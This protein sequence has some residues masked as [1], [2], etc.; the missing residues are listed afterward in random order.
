MATKVKF[1]LALLVLSGFC[2]DTTFAEV[3][4]EQARTIAREAYLYGFPIVD[5]YRIMYSYTQDRG[6]KEYKGPVNEVHGEARVFTPEDKALQTPNS[7][8]PYS[9]LVA[10]LRE[11]PLV[12]TVPEVEK[13]RYV[14]VQLIDLY[15]FNFEY[16]GTRTTGNGGGRYLLVGPSE[17]IDETP[18]GIQKILRAET[19]LVLAIYRTQLFGPDDLVNV[20]KIQEGYQAE[21]LWKYLKQPPK[22]QTPVLPLIKPLAA[23]DER[24]SVEFFDILRFALGLCPVHPEEKELRERF[25]KINLDM[26]GPAPSALPAD[27]K[28]AMKEG[29]EDGQREI[30]AK[31]GETHSASEI[32]GSRAFLQGNFLNRA[33]G[34]QM[35]IYGNSKEEAFY[36]GWSTESDQVTPLDTAKNRYVVRF[37]P[38][39]LPPVQAFWSVTMYDLP[40]Q[41]LVPNKLKRYL[42][43]SPMLPDLKK[44]AD[45]GLTIYIQKNSPGKDKESN[46]LPAPNGNAFIILRAYLPGPEILHGTWKVPPIERVK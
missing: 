24:T 16:L 37:G 41:L 39:Q 38:G 4:P 28:A 43:N 9:M 40:A 5:N 10:D 20:K 1:S 23:P 31:R 17:R 14:S 36:G 8:T 35:G 29:M 6:D 27:V 21:P 13:G 2:A 3:N 32:M 45:G 22:P 34:T 42:I 25:R 33:V 12:L 15:T 19:N 7:D 46:W 18:E 44:D 30:D 11:G 26:G